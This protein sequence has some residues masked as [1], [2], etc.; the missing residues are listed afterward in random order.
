MLL[1]DSPASLLRYSLLGLGD[2]PTMYAGA[3]LVG[4]GFCF[5]N[6]D[7]KQKQHQEQELNQINKEIERKHKTLNFWKLKN[8][9][10]CRL[11]RI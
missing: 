11:C 1:R 4:I 7:Q 9:K 3:V 10:S 8:R 6:N 5:L 2:L